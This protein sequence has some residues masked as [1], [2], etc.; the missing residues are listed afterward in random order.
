M[1]S[2]VEFAT[3]DVKKSVIAA[4]NLDQLE[5]CRL[6]WV[7]RKGVLTQYSKQIATVPQADRKQLGQ[8]INKLRQ[9]FE[10]SFAERKQQLETAFLQQKLAA[11][12]IDYTLPGRQVEQSSR[13]PV[14]ITIDKISQIFTSLGFS[15][16]S[17]PE[18]ESDYYNF[19]ALNIASNHPA[20]DMH[21]TFYLA[22]NLLLRTHTS[23]V[24]VRVMEK[25]KPPL[26]IICPGKV[27]RKDSDQTHTPMFHQV[28][29]LVIDSKVTFG[30]LKNLLINFF[31]CYFEDDNLKLRF[32]PSYFPFTEPSAEVDIQCSQCAGNGCRVCSNTGYLEVAGCG[33]VNTNVLKYSNIDYNK[34]NGFAFGMGVERLA[35]LKYAVSDLRSFFENNIDFLQQF[36]GL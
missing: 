7:G 22:D 16:E 35:M 17:G 4:D 1:N 9:Q 12:K 8:T 32:R 24:Q 36:K 20:R 15:I 5:Q 26:A 13:H 6:Y 21:D 14:A 25:S 18:I 29:G 34:F 33:M 31:K 11:E 23:P 3:D 30:Q 2:I 28:E 27:Y 10:S 19:A